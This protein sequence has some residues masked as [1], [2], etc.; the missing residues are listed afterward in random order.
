MDTYPNTCEDLEPPPPGCTETEQLQY[1]QLLTDYTNDMLQSYRESGIHCAELW[2]DFLTAFRPDSIRSW[3]RAQVTTWVY[4]LHDQGVHVERPRNQSR[5]DNL[6]NL[7][8]IR[9]HIAAGTVDP[10]NLPSTTPYKEVSQELPIMS[11]TLPTASKTSCVGRMT[12][13]HQDYR[14]KTSLRK[15][16]VRTTGSPSWAWPWKQGNQ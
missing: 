15:Q 7:L 8:Y 3:T 2:S 4:F 9:S 12:A 6:V 13:H 14:V 11:P 1:T 5:W 10:H 16:D